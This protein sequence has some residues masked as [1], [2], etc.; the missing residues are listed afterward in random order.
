MLTNTESTKKTKKEN[1]KALLNLFL[2]HDQERIVQAFADASRMFEVY[3]ESE[4]ADD[5]EERRQFV[6]SSTILA[7]C[8]VFVETTSEK[9]ISKLLNKSRKSLNN[10]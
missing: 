1:Y 3:L 7:E 5:S 8:K 6:Y 10:A 4:Y 2:G 9:K